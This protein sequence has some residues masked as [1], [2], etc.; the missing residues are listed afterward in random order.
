MTTGCPECDLRRIG[1]PVPTSAGQGKPEPTEAQRA[2]G[3]PEGQE[4][5]P[6]RRGRPDLE[7]WS[8]EGRPVVILLTP[9]LRDDGRCRYRPR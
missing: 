9:L 4:F 6:E 5:P 1:E 8:S 2:E 7:H 3:I